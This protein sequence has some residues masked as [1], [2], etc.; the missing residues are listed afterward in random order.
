VLIARRAVGD[1]VALAVAM[2]A[3]V[4]ATRAAFGG[5]AASRPAMRA[6]AVRPGPRGRAVLLMNPKSGGGKVERFQLAEEA[7]RRDIEPVLLGPDDDLKALA[8]EAA[9][10]AEVIG[11]AGGDGSQAL[12]ALVA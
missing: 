8:R 10:R 4:L 12:V 9:G 2:A 3:F 1:L 7:R 5:A 6:R 11:M